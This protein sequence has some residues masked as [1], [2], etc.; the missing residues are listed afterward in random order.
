MVEVMALYGLRREEVFDMKINQYDHANK[1]LTV[2]QGKGGKVRLVSDSS[3]DLCW[4]LLET[5]AKRLEEADEKR[6]RN[7]TLKINSAK[8]RAA[9]RLRV[10]PIHCSPPC[11]AYGNYFNTHY[12]C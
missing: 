12:P 2:G 10:T 3:V 1:T 6:R 11:N 9:E 5:V 8:L 4:R 7:P